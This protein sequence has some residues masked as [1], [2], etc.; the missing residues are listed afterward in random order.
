ML[1]R[2]PQGRHLNDGENANGETND[3]T[4]MHLEKN[5]YRMELDKGNK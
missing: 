3:R 4:N 1:E 5:D 2:S